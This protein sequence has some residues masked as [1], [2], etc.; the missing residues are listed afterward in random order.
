[1]MGQHTLT[2]KQAILLSLLMLSGS[3]KRVEG[4]SAKE[5]WEALTQ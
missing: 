4:F 1:M 3:H 5:I 2:R